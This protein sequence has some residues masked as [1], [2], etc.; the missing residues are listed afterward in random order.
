MI[1]PVMNGQSDKIVG[2]DAVNDHIGKPIPSTLWH[3]TSYAALQGIIS[4][5][6]VWATE[7]R[8][9]NDREEFLH[10]KELAQKAR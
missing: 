2:C 7:Y 5:K 1:Q 6:R 9:L 8:F 3:Y 4:S 10:A